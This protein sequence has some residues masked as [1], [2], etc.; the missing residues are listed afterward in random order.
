MSETAKGGTGRLQ[1]E[2]EESTGT[3]D[4]AAPTTQPHGEGL[5][6]T[7]HGWPAEAD[8]ADRCFDDVTGNA[9][10]HHGGAWHEVTVRARDGSAP[11]ARNAREWN[12]SQRDGHS[13][14]EAQRRRHRSP[15]K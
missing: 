4:G 15:A 6:Y 10:V 9:W 8:N 14:R 3:K 7:R 2:E 13:Y 1:S 12:W 11:V 5:R